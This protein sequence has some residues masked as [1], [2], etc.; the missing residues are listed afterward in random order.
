VLPADLGAALRS[1]QTVHSLP[2]AFFD[3]PPP[4]PLPL[5]LLLSFSLSLATAV[6]ATGS[7][8]AAEA[9]GA[10]E[11]APILQD[12]AGAQGVRVSS[13]TFLSG[14]G[15]SMRCKT[16][17][18]GGCVLYVR[19]NTHARSSQLTGRQRTGVTTAEEVG[20]E[21]TKP[22]SGTQRSRRTAEQESEPGARQV[23]AEQQTG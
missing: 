10:D 11:V 22:E 6:G 18:F 15:G 14:R 8:P 7:A 1:E 20:G 23:S 21:T 16:K 9:A 2:V 19:T 4:L 5:P 13:L 12:R 3:L 17:V